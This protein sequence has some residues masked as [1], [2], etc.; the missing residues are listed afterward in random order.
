MKQKQ[1]CV[2]CPF[3]FGLSILVFFRKKNQKNQKGKKEKSKFLMKRQRNNKETDEQEAKR[4]RVMSA[5]NEMNRVAHEREQNRQEEFKHWPTSSSSLDLL[6]PTFL[7]SL[8]APVRNIEEEDK[9]WQEWREARQR[10]EEEEKNMEKYKE[11]ELKRAQL[12]HMPDVAA[13]YSLFK[14]PTWRGRGPIP[15]K[16]APN[17]RMTKEEEKYYPLE[18]EKDSLFNLHELTNLIHEYSNPKYLVP[19]EKCQTL[20]SLPSST[21]ESKEE[22]VK[23]PCLLQVE[24]LAEYIKSDEYRRIGYARFEDFDCALYCLLTNL[25][26]QFNLML[27]EDDDEREKE[28]I[29]P[30]SLNFRIRLKNPDTKLWMNI[31]HDEKSNGYVTRVSTILGNGKYVKATISLE[32]AIDLIL[33]YGPRAN[34]LFGINNSENDYY[35]KNFGKNGYWNLISGAANPEDLIYDHLFSIRGDLY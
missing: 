8:P 6:S 20:T 30:F 7:R 2:F 3:F 18:G 22:K 24:R 1:V 27:K 11:E 5:I 23:S 19:H 29:E 16:L 15:Y 14:G 35:L 13:I 21:I 4:S 32:E 26:I 10:E 28:L 34:I 9:G 17:Q 25:P 31:E 33:Y 12:P